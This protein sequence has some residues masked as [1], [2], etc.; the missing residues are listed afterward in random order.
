MV[1]QRWNS[2]AKPH[3]TE[4]I[5]FEIVHLAYVT[6]SEV[7]FITELIVVTMP[8][9]DITEAFSSRNRRGIL[10]TQSNIDDETFCEKLKSFVKS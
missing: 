9:D 7:F 1:E 3:I 6:F 8:F 2:Y 5:S 4:K 10:K